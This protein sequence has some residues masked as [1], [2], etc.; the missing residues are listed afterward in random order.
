MEVNYFCS[1]LI[2]AAQTGNEKVIEM[3]LQRDAVVNV[4]LQLVNNNKKETTKSLSYRKPEPEEE[5]E[6]KLIFGTFKS[7]SFGKEYEECELGFTPLHYVMKCQK[8]AATQL[9]LDHGANINEASELGLTSLFVACKHNDVDLVKSFLK[10]GADIKTQ[11]S[12]GENLL[13]YIIGCIIEDSFQDSYDEYI[14]YEWIDRSKV[15]SYLLKIGADPNGWSMKNKESVLHCAAKNGVP[16]VVHLLLKYGANVNSVDGE[17]KTP[18]EYAVNNLKEILEDIQDVYYCYDSS[19]DEDYR[20]DFFDDSEEEEEHMREMDD[21]RK[22]REANRKR[23]FDNRKIYNLTHNKY[24]YNKFKYEKD[25]GN[26]EGYTI[27]KDPQPLRLV[28]QLIVR[29]LV[30]LEALGKKNAQQNVKFLQTK[31][32]KPY[33]TRCKNELKKMKTNVIAD[34]VSYYDFLFAND[35]KLKEYMKNGKIASEITEE[36]CRQLFPNYTRDLK[37]NAKRVMKRK[38]SVVDE[39]SSGSSDDDV[40]AGGRAKRRR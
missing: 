11:V 4:K 25:H 12:N 2:C 32:V 36:N 14:K 9:L 8:Q 39:E 40:Q 24:T 1:P 22:Q 18:I 13:C 28:A 5:Y 34:G 6:K 35:V 27:F 17:L 3:L 29:E 26:N 38:K 7:H 30:R 20:N 37:L 10:A 31:F 15:F 19:S 33:Y 16:H 23:K 21:R